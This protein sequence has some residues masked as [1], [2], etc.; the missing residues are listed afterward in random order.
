MMTKKD[1][2]LIAVGL[3]QSKPYDRF[4]NSEDIAE[5]HNMQYKQSVA[6]VATALGAQN[7]K[8][9]RDKF[10][11]MCGIEPEVFSQRLGTDWK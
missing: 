3:L 4:F 11:K 5:G 1:Y 7:P 2:E 6:T 9:D 8:F 10:F